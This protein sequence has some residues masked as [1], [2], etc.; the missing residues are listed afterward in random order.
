LATAQSFAGWFVRRIADRLTGEAHQ[1][2]AGQFRRW[3]AFTPNQQRQILAIAIE[4]S[5]LLFSAGENR[6]I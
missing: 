6:Q 1:E 5:T 4:L 3:S 2:A